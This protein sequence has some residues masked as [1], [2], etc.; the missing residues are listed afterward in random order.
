MAEEKNSARDIE[1][2]DDII[3]WDV[4][5]YQGEKKDKRWYI[6][7]SIFGLAFLVYAIFTSNLIF[8][9]IIIF[10]AML[11]IMLDGEPAKTMSVEISDEGIRVGKEFYDYNQIDN[12]SIVYRPKE[13]V[14]NLYLEFKRFVRPTLP[15]NE[16]RRY[17]WLL[18]LANFAR[19]RLSLPLLDMNPLLIRKNLLKYLKEDV[20]RIDI[21]LSEQLARFFKL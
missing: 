18:W 2:E 13:E 15:D 14:K 5:E 11:V 10:A 3:A 6:I 4:P 12:F 1:S 8:A 9:I 20:D 16:P 21:P 7:A 17:E 19:T